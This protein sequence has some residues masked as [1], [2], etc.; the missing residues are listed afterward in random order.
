M[1]VDKKFAKIMACLTMI[2]LLFVIAIIPAHAEPT[3]KAVTSHISPL[4]QYKAGI[5]LKDIK[6]EEGLQLIIKSKDLSPACVKPSTA[7]KLVTLGWGKLESTSIEDLEQTSIKTVTLDDN[8]KS[9]SIKKDERFL[10]K[11]GEA[12]DWDISIDDQS[13]VSRITNVMAIKGTQGLYQ[14]HNIGQTILTATGNPWCYTA[15]PACMMPSIQ[16]KIDIIVTE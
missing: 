14:G 15:K 2:S 4:K 8:E 12:Y 9:V 10:L 13:I 1:S 5:N 3:S 16:F 6:C 7:N 11:L